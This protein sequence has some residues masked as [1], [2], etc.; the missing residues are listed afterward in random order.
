ME[1]IISQARPNGNTRVNA[2]RGKNQP[3]P[4]PEG[5][6]TLKRS[7]KLFN[8]DLRRSLLGELS[9]N[10]NLSQGTA[11]QFQESAESPFPAGRNKH[12]V[13]GQWRQLVGKVIQG[14]LF[15]PTPVLG[16]RQV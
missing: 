1:T 6:S 16:K 12:R 2:G 11:N 15:A 8:F 5:T 4:V 13:P 7:F 9:W 14:L 10:A 3:S